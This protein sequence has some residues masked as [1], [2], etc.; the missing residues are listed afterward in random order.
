MS[1]GAG[2]G[3]A[4]LGAMGQQQMALE[5]QPSIALPAAHQQ[6]LFLLE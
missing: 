2:P 6:E 4:V 5:H 1:L 3:L